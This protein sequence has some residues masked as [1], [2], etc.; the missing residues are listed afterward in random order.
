MHA[1][2]HTCAM[3]LP[4]PLALPCHIGPGNAIHSVTI[5]AKVIRRLGS[6]RSYIMS[7]QS[8]PCPLNATRVA[9]EQATSCAREC[10]KA[11]EVATLAANEAEKVAGTHQKVAAAAAE[12]AADKAAEAAEAA[13]AAA[14]AAEAAVGAAAT[15]WALAQA[16]PG[17]AQSGAL[18]A[19]PKPCQQST[20]EGS[21][22]TVEGSRCTIEGGNSSSSSLQQ[23]LLSLTIP[24]IP[25]IVETVREVY[26]AYE[27]DQLNIEK[28][29]ALLKLPDHYIATYGRWN[30]LAGHRGHLMAMH[31]QAHRKEWEA[32]QQQQ[33]Q[34]QQSEAPKY[35]KYK[36]PPVVFLQAEWCVRS[37]SPL[38]LLKAAPQPKPLKAASPPIPLKAAPQ[39]KPLKAASPPIPS[40]AAPPHLVLQHERH[41]QQQLEEQL[42]KDLLPQQQKQWVDM[43]PGTEHR[44]KTEPKFGRLANSRI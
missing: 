40:K 41:E 11:A 37:A 20:I 30:V 6:S 15:R 8:E 14:A 27:K 5:L 36:A 21:G 19:P 29:D 4:S 17:G 26:N 42:D 12:V 25:L 32:M 39:P 35:P 1:C 9:A 23:Q 18:G 13:A 10:R 43:G 44:P 31:Q 7:F 2:I 16:T 3:P 33:Q 22:C 38:E 24:N 34:Q 28:M